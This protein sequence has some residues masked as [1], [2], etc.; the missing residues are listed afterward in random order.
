MGYL[1]SHDGFHNVPLVHKHALCDGDLVLQK[2][3]E[4]TLLFATH[5]MSNIFRCGLER[6]ALGDKHEFYGASAGK[7][8]NY[9]S[10]NDV[11]DVAVKA[12]CEKTHQRQ[13]YTLTGP[14]P[15]T[16][17][18]VATL[19]TEQL[20]TPITY[21]EN[22]LNFFDKDTAALEQVKATGLEENFPKG[23]FKKVVGRDA[24]TFE[25]YLKATE[26]MTPVEQEVFEIVTPDKGATETPIEVAEK[27]VQDTTTDVVQPTV[28]AQ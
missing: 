18:E 2:R 19:L 8:V 15:L 17:T 24:E 14:N 21:V 11:A 9:V 23:D 7:G 25:G 12:I 16:D 6:K 13:A 4:V 27:T 10:P 20:G 1:P 26:R 5:L 3:F 28:E 22:P